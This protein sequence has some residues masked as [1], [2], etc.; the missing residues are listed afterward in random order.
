[1]GKGWRGEREGWSYIMELSDTQEL[2]KPICHHNKRARITPQ[3]TTQGSAS[4][5]MPP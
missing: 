1:M 4:T 3:I 2:R 5:T